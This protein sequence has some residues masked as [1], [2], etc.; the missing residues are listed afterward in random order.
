MIA[1]DSMTKAERKVYEAAVSAL[2]DGIAASDFSQRFFGPEGMLGHLCKTKEDRQAL[3]MSDLYQWL[4]DQL[5]ELRRRESEAFRRE[6]EALSGRLTVVVPK[7]LHGALRRE[8]V[9]EGVSLSEL[10]RLKLAVPFAMTTGMVTMRHG[11]SAR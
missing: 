1:I 11:S 2:Q 9:E 7:S 5:T 8:A 6:V 3:A 4:Q 10:I